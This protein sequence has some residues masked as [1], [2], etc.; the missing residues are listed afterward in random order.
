MECQLY[1][2]LLQEKKKR[3]NPMV[4]RFEYEIDYSSTPS[5]FIVDDAIQERNTI[6]YVIFP[7]IFHFALISFCFIYLEF[8][9]KF[10]FCVSLCGGLKIFLFFCDTFSK[11][12]K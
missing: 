1:G 6:K 7:S 11:I 12:G 8:I 10:I 2:S 4:V 9:N 3:L 5:C